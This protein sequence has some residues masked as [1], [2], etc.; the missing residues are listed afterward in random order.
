MKRHPNCKVLIHRPH[1][2]LGEYSN[3][4]TLLMHC[5]IGKTPEVDGDPFDAAVD[6]P[7]DCRAL[8]S[9]LW[10]LQV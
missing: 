5:S 10:E 6:D 2:P 7:K 3:L 4:T 1:P 9:C 8:E